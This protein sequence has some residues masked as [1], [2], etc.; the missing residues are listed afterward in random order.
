M[1]K[2]MFYPSI[3]YDG[4]YY[5]YYVV[6]TIKSKY[7]LLDFQVEHKKGNLLAA[8]IYH[9]NWYE[10][11]YKRRFIMVFWICFQK[12]LT[13]R[14]L[15]R[16]NKKIIWTVHNNK[17][18]DSKYSWIE[19]LLIKAICKYADRIH[20]LCNETRN[21]DFLKKYQN[22]IVH[23][24]HGDYIG[25]YPSSNINIRSKYNIPNNKKILLFIGQI[26]K[27]K[28]IEVLIDSFNKSKINK[29]FVLL[30]CGNCF[31]ESYKNELS[32]INYDNIIF[33]FNFIKDEEMS[34]YLR[35]ASLIIAPYD[36]ESSLNSGTLWMA[37]S[38]KKTMILPLIG[39]VKDLN[40]DELLY[41]YDY[42]NKNEHTNNLTNCLNKIYDDFKNDKD[43]FDK[44]GNKCFNYV[45][46]NITWN[47]NKKKW[48]DLYKFD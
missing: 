14:K 23:I 15:K 7:R 4:N 21:L 9:L 11:T 20:I 5:L 40:Y 36:I 45:K 31:D 3:H 8:D 35:E 10:S 34:S 44:K 2:I 41:V 13:I 46:D 6:N 19:L 42:R 29:E 28:N 22:K 32:G 30:I 12:Y 26:K 16:N 1:K 47:K 25:C 48:I 27:Y 38:Y 17:P 43:I 37:M 24:P 39:C 33:D 18:H